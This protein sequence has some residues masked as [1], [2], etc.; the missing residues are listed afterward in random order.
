MSQLIE[1]LELLTGQ[2]SNMK[3][4]F[5][6]AINLEN[7]EKGH[8]GVSQMNELLLTAGFDRI[9]NSY[10]ALLCNE[11]PIKYEDGLTINGIK[12]LTNK[13]LSIRKFAALKYGNFKFA[14]KKWASMDEQELSDE[15]SEMLPPREIYFSSRTD[16]LED[17]ELIDIK[18]TYLL[19]EIT[20]GQA[21]IEDNELLERQ[22]EARL[23]G[24]K[25]FQKYLTFDH[26]DVYVATS[27]RKRKDYISVGNF[28]KGVFNHPTIK[29]LKLRY[30]DPTQSYSKSRFCK[31]LIECLILK[32]AKC[33]I[34]CV[35]E[36]DTFGKDSELA[37]TLAQGKPVLAWVP[38]I[39]NIKN[40]AQ[41]LIDDSSNENKEKP[42]EAMRVYYFSHFP[43]HAVNNPHF[44]QTAKIDELS[45]ELA[46]LLR[47]RFNTRAQ[48]LKDVHPLSLQ[49]DLNTGVAHGLIVIRDVEE[50]SEILYKVLNRELTFKF[51]EI[52]PEYPEFACGDYK[53]TYIL[54]EQQT[55]SPYR[56]IIGDE[57]LTNA[58][59][60]FY[61]E[62]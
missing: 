53:K 20:G 35:Q 16:P 30:F 52:D 1:Q 23:K 49:I 31:G 9:S 37:I 33:S 26:M 43:E 47:E 24:E 48:I 6:N 39:D 59:W 27:M 38:R 60:N 40:Y 17:I 28:I 54:R 15:I 58:F 45:D 21:K 25:N 55:N 44:A 18:D 3:A 32:R 34:Y 29:P 8:I 36:T 62:K 14:F 7:F 2:A 22:K 10:F 12:E 4:Y 51:E 19:G 13:V 46:K 56:I 50:C 57:L 5:D 42:I 11:K 61:L 41:S